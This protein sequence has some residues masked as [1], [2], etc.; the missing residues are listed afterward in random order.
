M[1]FLFVFGSG[2][3]EYDLIVV[4][5]NALKFSTWLLVTDEITGMSKKRGEVLYLKSRCYLL[6]IFLSSALFASYWVVGKF[7]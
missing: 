5:H 1:T 3:S 6:I 2:Q 7:L 4:R